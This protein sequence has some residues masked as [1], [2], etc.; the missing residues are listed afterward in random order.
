MATKCKARK[1]N[2]KRCDAWALQGK[3]KCALHS[4]PELPAKMG[5]MQRRGTVGQPD[6]DTAMLPLPKTA[7]E[8]RDS[9]AT[10]MA[11]V[12]A[13]KMDTKTANAL[14]YVGTSLLRAIEVSGLEERVRKM[15]L[16]ANSE[17]DKRNVEP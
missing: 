4:D 10:A 17:E 15:E 9:L 11:Q 1:R 13:R 14:S 7:I 2:G 8:V 16:Q 5:A 6:K 3:T 12:Q